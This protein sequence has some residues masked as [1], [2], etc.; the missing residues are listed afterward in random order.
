MK[1]EIVLIPHGNGCWNWML[2]I[3]DVFIDGS[4][5]SS[6]IAAFMAACIAYDKESYS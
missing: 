6:R 3:D 4:I 1:R 5:E 2:Y